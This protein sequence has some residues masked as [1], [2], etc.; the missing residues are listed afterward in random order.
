MKRIA[1]T[2]KESGYDDFGVDMDLPDDVLNLDWK[3]LSYRYL[4]PA[5]ERIRDERSVDDRVPYQA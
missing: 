1:I 5:L 2:L 3:A 4:I